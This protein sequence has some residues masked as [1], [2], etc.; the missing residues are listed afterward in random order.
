MVIPRH[1]EC[2]L[3]GRV[4]GINLRYFIVKSKCYYV[5]YAGGCS[6]NKKHH[7]C[8]DCMSLICEYVR[9]KEGD[10]DDG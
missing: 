7:I 4:V 9:E 8:E 6:D 3:C 10:I 1:K 5:G 2:D